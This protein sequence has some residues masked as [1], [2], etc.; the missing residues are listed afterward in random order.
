MAGYLVEMKRH[1][2]PWRTALILLILFLCLLLVWNRGRRA[3]DRLRFSPPGQPNTSDQMDTTKESQVPA[4]DIRLLLGQV[5]PASH[6]AFVP[7]EASVAARPGMF[8]H[9][10][11]HEAFMRMHAAA[12]ADGVDLFIISAMRGFAHQKRIWEDKWHGRRILYG[13]IY[14][15]DIQEATDRAREIL[16]FSA[17][18]GTSRHHWGTDVDLNSLDNRYFESGPGQ[19][20]YDWLK[21]H[22]PDFGFCQPY[23]ALGKHRGGGYEEEKW[24]WSYQPVASLY[25]AAYREQVSYGDIGDFSGWETAEQLDVIRHYVLQVDPSCH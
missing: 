13:G 2:K 6:P 9:G 19:Q 4:V 7:V 5:D 16:R 22:A 24:H 18:P 15:T 25:L 23:T 17:M 8:M 11:A 20:V 14:A 1:R 21:M 10:E 12:H 3:A